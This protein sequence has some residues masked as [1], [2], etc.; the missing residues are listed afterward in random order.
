MLFVL[1]NEIVGRT[2]F[3]WIRATMLLMML[4]SIGRA[5]I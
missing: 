5:Y 4:L 1:R 2:R 3:K